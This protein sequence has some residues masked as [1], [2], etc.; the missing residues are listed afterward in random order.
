MLVN[1]FSARTKREVGSNLRRAAKKDGRRD[2]AVDEAAGTTS[3][4]TSAET[5]TYN[6]SLA[7]K[8]VF[9]FDSTSYQLEIE[10]E[11]EEGDKDYWIAQYQKLL[12]SKPKLLIDAVRQRFHSLTLR[13]LIAFVSQENTCDPA[14]KA[15]LDDCDAGHHLV[16]FARHK[17]TMDVLKTLSLDELKKASLSVE[18]TFLIVIFL[19]DWGL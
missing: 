3:L 18:V 15:I 10:N 8:H 12:L 13:D 14:V 4:A 16:E 7:S 6:V 2:G 17:V 9:I 19:A 5:C 1:D 11:K